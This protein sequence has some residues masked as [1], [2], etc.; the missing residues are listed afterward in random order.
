MAGEARDFK[1]KAVIIT[2]GGSGVGLE[3][4]KLFAAAGANILI[5]GRN[6]EKLGLACDIIGAQSI[7]FA[8]DVSQSET[9]QV[10]M[11][12]C[13][14]H[15]GRAADILINNAGVILRKTAEETSDSEW[16]HILAV[17]VTGVFNFSRAFA[18]QCSGKGAI[19]NVSSTCGQVGAAGIAAYCASKGAVDQLTRSIALELAPRGITVNAVAPGAINSPMLFSKHEDEGQAKTV[20]SSNME[21]I[22]IGNIA[23]P[24]EVAR[25][26]LFLAREQ[27]ITGTILSIDGGY[28]AV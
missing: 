15:F 16:E 7:Y 26:I 6:T 27:H 17:N 28:T 25:A 2:G 19:V 4:A 3:T 5:T 18:K 22:P 1:D 23:E 24:N 20:V 12:K 8:G 14:D 9:A 11:T 13:Q 21:S 10:A